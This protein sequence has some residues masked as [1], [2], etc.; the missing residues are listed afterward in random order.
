V[1][2][3]VL[4]A[5]ALVGAVL[6]LA[7]LSLAPLSIAFARWIVPG[8][9]VF[10]ARWRFAHVVWVVIAFAALN[11]ASGVVWQLSRG[12]AKPSVMDELGLTVVMHV[13]VAAVIWRCAVRMDPDG[14]RSLG[15]WR[16]G[17][18]RAA[19]AGVVVYVLALPGVVG[20][21]PLWV[22]TLGRFGFAAQP[23]EIAE[24]ALDLQGP[25]LIAFVVLA[26][27]VVPFFEEL[28][29]RAFLQP[30]L[31]QNLGDRGG[32]VVTSIL[33]AAL[34]G[35]SAFLPIFGL[36][37]VLGSIMLRTQRL[38]ASWLVHALHNGSMLALLF[39]WPDSS[40]V[41]GQ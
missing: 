20:L 13:G 32:V 11:A 26:T 14:W 9:N 2:G 33:F 15:L 21:G 24:R 41:L 30:L 37:L 29:F 35:L 6:V 4:G 5:T 36:S 8:R 34:H 28:L 38:T 40:H 25:E 17:H 3:D 10:F 19:L 27:L 22:W 7:S 12:D 1:S 39:L 31:V 23:Q 16:G 18:A